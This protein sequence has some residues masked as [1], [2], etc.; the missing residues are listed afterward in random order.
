MIHYRPAVPEDAEALWAMFLALDEETDFMMYAPGERSA[1]TDIARLCAGLERTRARGDLLEL[2]LD[3]ETPVGFLHAERGGFQRNA[4]CAG[5]VVGTRAAWRRQGIGT[6][7]FREAERW[8]GENGVTRL[9]LTVECPN[10]AAQALYKR[11]GFR[12]EGTRAR[13]MRVGGQYVDEYYM[14]KLL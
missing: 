6:A 7:L 13:S 4:H 9:E 1:R 2:A 14:A 3:G 11:C 8:A 12:V 5:I 10:L